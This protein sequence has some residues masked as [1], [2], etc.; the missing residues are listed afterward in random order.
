MA[1]FHRIKNGLVVN[2]EVWNVQPVDGG[3]FVFIPA[4]TGGPGWTW[5]GTNLIPPPPPPI[6]PIPQITFVRR[7]ITEGLWDAFSDVMAATAVRRRVWDQMKMTGDPI[8]SASVPVRNLLT[9][10]GATQAQIDRIMDP[11]FP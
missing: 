2:T 11:S 5:D 7:V 3:G 8:D 1:R 6:P 4:N 10:A 9:A